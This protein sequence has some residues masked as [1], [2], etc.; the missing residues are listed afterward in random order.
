MLIVSEAEEDE[1]DIIR[2]NSNKLPENN[3][4]NEEQVS[5]NPIEEESKSSKNKDE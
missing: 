3:N 4:I 5:S 1:N 2:D